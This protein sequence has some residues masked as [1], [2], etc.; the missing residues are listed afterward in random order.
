MGLGSEEN[1][2]SPKKAAR[3]KS[4]WNPTAIANESNAM[5]LIDRNG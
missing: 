5:S 3:E 2:V 4:R 1:K